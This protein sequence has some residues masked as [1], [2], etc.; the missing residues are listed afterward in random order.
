MKHK[1]VNAE[2]TKKECMKTPKI[3]KFVKPTIEEKRK[4]AEL[5]ISVFIAKNCSL[6]AVDDL[7]KLISDLDPNSEALGKIK[8]HRTKCTGII[9]KQNK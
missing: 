8:L 4:K 3:D 6:S 1:H 9:I 5:K 2:K 7:G